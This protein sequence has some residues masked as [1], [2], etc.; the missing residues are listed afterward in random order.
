MDFF[1]IG[2]NDLTQYTLAVDRGN[3]MIS[4]MYQ[5]A[6]TSVLTLIKMVD[7]R[8][9]DDMASGPVCA[10]NWLVTNAPPLLLL[11]MGLMSSP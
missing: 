9:H 4:A 7:R 5:P 11:G 3:E 2:T 1:S 10:V 8:S 6:V